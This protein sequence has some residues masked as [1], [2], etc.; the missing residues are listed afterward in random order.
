MNNETVEA[1]KQQLEKEQRS[2]NARRVMLDALMSDEEASDLT[3]L[4][5]P[6]VQGLLSGRIETLRGQQKIT[7]AVGTF[8]W[9]GIEPQPDLPG[10]DG[11]LI[12]KTVWRGAKLRRGYHTLASP[13]EAERT[14]FAESLAALVTPELLAAAERQRA[15]FPVR[16]IGRI[17]QIFGP[18][19]APA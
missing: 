2:L 9:K 8:V 19:G 1:E 3:G 11:Q 15:R 4:E 6:T 17:A 5:I 10:E 18:I 14:E 7:N 12:A 13:S 16:L